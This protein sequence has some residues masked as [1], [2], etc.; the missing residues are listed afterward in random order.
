MH[1]VLPVAPLLKSA[2][3]PVERNVAHMSV[4]RRGVLSAAWH[5]LASASPWEALAQSRQGSTE[6]EFKAQVAATPLCAAAAACYGGGDGGGALSGIV[7]PEEV[8]E[9]KG[10]GGELLPSS[11]MGRK[12]R[13]CTKSC[14]GYCC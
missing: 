2:A 6:E 1:H 12:H 7:P 11:C 13:A 3:V 14:L 8:R 5:R 10:G 9:G 4:T